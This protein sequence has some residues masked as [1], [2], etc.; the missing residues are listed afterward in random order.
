MQ[1]SG[2]SLC[3][4]ENPLYKKIPSEKNLLLTKIKLLQISVHSQ[5]RNCI[6]FFSP[7]KIKRSILSLCNHGVSQRKRIR[8]VRNNS[9]LTKPHLCS[10]L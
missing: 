5:E 4:G 3:K 8:T 7:N 2:C 9:V 10:K 1:K 6:I